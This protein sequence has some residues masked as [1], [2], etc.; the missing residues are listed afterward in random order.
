MDPYIIVQS[1]ESKLSGE[2]V[3]QVAKMLISPSIVKDYGMLF[4]F[5][6]E[7]EDMVFPFFS[8]K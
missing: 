6:V 5:N 8:W 3:R 4:P 7:R 2:W 1:Y